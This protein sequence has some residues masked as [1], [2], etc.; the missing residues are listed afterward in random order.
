MNTSAFDYYCFKVRVQ[1]LNIKLVDYILCDVK[2]FLADTQPLI[3]CFCARFDVCV[4]E[5]TK[6]CGNLH[7]L[8][9]RQGVEGLMAFR[10]ELQSELN[11]PVRFISTVK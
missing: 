3:E 9:E 11:R 7:V 1:T 2:A 6:I 5:V 8:V 10:D 4:A